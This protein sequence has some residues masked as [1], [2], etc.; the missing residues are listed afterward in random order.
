MNLLRTLAFFLFELITV[1][2]W[3]V[4]AIV[5]AVF[6]R[7]IHY[8][9]VMFWLD[10]QIWAARVI[11]GIRHQVIGAENL[12]DGPAILLSKHQSTWET[13]FYPTFMPRQLCSLLWMGHWPARHDSYQSI[14]RSRCV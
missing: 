7:P 5:T 9:I 10:M 3:S 1:I 12:P 6:P 4:L 11:L 13:F 14:Q 2:P 8:S